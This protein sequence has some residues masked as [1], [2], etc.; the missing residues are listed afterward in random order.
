MA[1]IAYLFAIVVAMLG[2][3]AFLWWCVAQ[4]I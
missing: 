1:R 3:L 4:V 2:W